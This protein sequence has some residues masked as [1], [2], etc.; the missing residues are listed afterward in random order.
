M[1]KEKYDAIKEDI[2]KKIKREESGLTTGGEVQQKSEKKEELNFVNRQ[3]PL[4][5]VTNAMIKSIMKVKSSE[6]DAIRAARKAKVLG[7]QPQNFPQ[8][9][10]QIKKKD[11]TSLKKE[12]WNKSKKF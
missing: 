2:L 12:I 7:Q 11:K 1:K 9:E 6:E 3:Q 4:I 8:L 10:K 5:R